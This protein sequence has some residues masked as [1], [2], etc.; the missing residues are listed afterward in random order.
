VILVAASDSKGTIYN[1]KGLKVEELIRIKDATGSVINYKDGEVLKTSDLLMISTDIF[2]PAARPDVISEA[3]SDV[4]DAKLV[5]EGANIP[6]TENAEKMLHDRGILVVPDFVANAGGVITASVEYH[7]GTEAQAL[8]RI[9]STIS[10][11]TKEILDKVYSE[12]TYPRETA[13]SI[14]RQRVLRAMKY[15]EWM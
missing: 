1:P 10:R 6:I 11:N 9:K 7:G 15:R 2:V 8:E 5:I 3:N 12:K 4:L 13:L 14:A